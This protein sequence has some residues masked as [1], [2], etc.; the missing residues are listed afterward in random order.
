[1]LD[2][3]NELLKEKNVDIPF[4]SILPTVLLAGEN[5]GTVMVAT[6][7]VMPRTANVSAGTSAFLMAVLEKPLV[8]YYKEID[9][10][11]TPHG[12]PVAMVHVNNFTSEMNAWA[13]LL[14]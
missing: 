2:K 11:T 8:S 5:A 9:V 4:E 12:A 6:N 3:F 14:E 1:M 13:S 7:S 10:V